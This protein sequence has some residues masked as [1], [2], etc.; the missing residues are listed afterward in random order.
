MA[1]VKVRNPEFLS[2]ILSLGGYSFD[3]L[4]GKVAL[5]NQGRRATKEFDLLQKG[6]YDMEPGI[7]ACDY[8][9]LHLR[10]TP[11]VVPTPVD[12]MNDL[13][14]RLTSSSS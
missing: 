12:T 14:G 9:C 11:K 1:S 6:F 3:P 8:G 7:R 5:R 13:L 4:T 2:Y 10:L